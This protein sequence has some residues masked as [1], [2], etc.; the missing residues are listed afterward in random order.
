MRTICSSMA[1][2]PRV[3][4]GRLLEEITV[5]N[6]GGRKFP[7]AYPPRRTRRSTGA[8]LPGERPRV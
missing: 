8:L 3:R 6:P 5:E 1:T 2:A 4:D 7:T